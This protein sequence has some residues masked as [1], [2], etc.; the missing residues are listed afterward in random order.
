M[1]I[2]YLTGMFFVEEFWHKNRL[3]LGCVHF[4][5]CSSENNFFMC[6]KGDV[7]L[8]GY[9]VRMCVTGMGV[10]NKMNFGLS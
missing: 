8:T 1:L 7:R 5:F 10:Y 6:E 9:Y 2:L 3:V 4:I